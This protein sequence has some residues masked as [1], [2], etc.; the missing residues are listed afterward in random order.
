MTFK[1]ERVSIDEINEEIKRNTRPTKS[2]LPWQLAHANNSKNER[3][4]VVRKSNPNAPVML[5]II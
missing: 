1:T 4:V 3:T 2:Y 5:G